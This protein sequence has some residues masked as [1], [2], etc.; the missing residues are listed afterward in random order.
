VMWT[1]WD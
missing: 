1:R